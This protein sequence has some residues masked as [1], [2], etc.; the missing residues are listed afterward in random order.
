M[1]PVIGITC[2]LTVSVPT[3]SLRASERNQVGL[4]YIRAIEYAGGTPLVLPYVQDSECIDHYLRL[5]DGLLLI[6]GVDVDPLLY[7]QEPHEK[8]GV[9]D[10]IRDDMELKLTRKALDEGRPIFAICR[11]VQLLNVAAGGTLY[12]DIASEISGSTL[13]HSQNGAGWYASHTVDIQPDSRLHR[14]VGDTT[15]RTNSFHHQAV[16][17]VGEGFIATAHA[18]DGVIEAIESD[19]HRFALGVQYHPEL[20]WER[21]PDALSLFTAFVKA[22]H[23]DD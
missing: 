23:Q 1:R 9:V 15:T 5:L 22:S 4:D 14:I 11:G 16:R 8:L 10:R 3:D 21:H 18:K 7:G 13:C 17:D 6:G 2:S 20:M 12:Q 19:M